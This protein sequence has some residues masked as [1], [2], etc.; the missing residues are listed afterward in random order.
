MARSRVDSTSVSLNVSTLPNFFHFPTPLTER[1]VPPNFTKKPSESMTDTVGKTVKME[2]RVSGSQPLTVSW[3]KDNREIFSSDKYQVS[4]QNNL[5]VLSIQDSSSSDTGLYSC[6]ASN[7]A[8]Q[9]SCGVSL[10][11]SGTTPFI[12][13]L[14]QGRWQWTPGSV[15]GSDLCLWTFS[16]L[17]VF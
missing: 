14:H 13:P 1:K 16:D 15:S 2:A 5:A 4:F 6:A 9:A 17:L 8:G 7:E 3:S 12:F 11:V 10:T